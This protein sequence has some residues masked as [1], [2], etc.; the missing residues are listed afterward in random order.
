MRERD[1]DFIKD[2]LRRN[3]FVRVLSV[4]VKEHPIALCYHG[5]SEHIDESNTPRKHTITFEALEQQMKILAELDFLDKKRPIDK[6]GKKHFVIITFDDGLESF[7][8]AYREILCYFET[9]V[10]LFI[11]TGFINTPSYLTLEQ[12]R[13]LKNNG[14]LVFSHT[15]LHTDMRL[16][17]PS[18]SQDV[19]ESIEWLASN[20]G[21][22]DCYEHFA[23]PGGHYS[24]DTLKLMAKIGFK[25]CW[26]ANYGYIDFKRP[27]ALNRIVIDKGIDARTFTSIVQGYTNALGPIWR[28]LKWFS[29]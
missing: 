11:N 8:H 28:F 16:N 26:T 4:P 10:Y 14:V 17:N 19:N 5:I 22:T 18:V 23:F 20:L 1:K 24:R 9:N 15:H 12:V 21:S 13:E 3:I 2:L 7:Y 6:I 29:S 25:F 27:L